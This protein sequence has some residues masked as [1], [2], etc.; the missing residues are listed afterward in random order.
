MDWWTEYI[1]PDD[2]FIVRAHK[3]VAWLIIY[4]SLWPIRILFGVWI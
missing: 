4:A 1:E 3:I 2:N